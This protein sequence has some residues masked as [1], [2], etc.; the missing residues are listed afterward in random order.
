[1]SRAPEETASWKPEID[2]EATAQELR[3]GLARAKARMREHREQML[4]AGLTSQPQ[5]P[6]APPA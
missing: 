1:M 6:E 4:A 2:P 5:D 3:D